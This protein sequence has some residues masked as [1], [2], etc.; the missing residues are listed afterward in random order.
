M[1]LLRCF[2]IE[3]VVGMKKGI[4]ALLFCL[5]IAAAGVNEIYAQDLHHVTYGVKMSSYYTIENSSSGKYLYKFRFTMESDDPSSYGC[6]LMKSYLYYGS[7]D[8]GGEFVVD[9]FLGTT[10]EDGELTTFEMVGTDSYT[11]KTVWT[12]EYESEE[13]LYDDSEVME[14]VMRVY[15]QG[16]YGATVQNLYISF[17]LDG[18][19][20]DLSATPTPTS[21]PEPTPTNT[22]KPTPTNTPVPTP[23]NTPV[24][25]PTNTPIP[26]NTPTPTPTPGPTLE[27]N[28]F[29]DD[30]IAV[31]QYYTGGCSPVKSIIEFYEVVETAD[32][33]TRTNS[34]TFLSGTGTMRNTM[35]PGKVY[36]Y[37]LTYIYQRDGIQYEDFLWS[38]DL[39]IVDQELEDYRNNGKITNFRTAMI[40]VWEQF[41]TLELP[42]EG[43]HI[44]FKEL[45]IWGMVASILLWVIYKFIE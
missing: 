5:L 35:I 26:T 32:I 9:R 16:N 15:F 34:E 4:F 22:P 40:C 21:T 31:A 18:E 17:T 33:L 7:Y 3:K 20:P 41:M 19:V 29:V 23:T 25:T 12:Y 42:V 8:L 43:F 45:F 24:P 39:S 14:I 13:L 30:T 6:A 2:D 37:K 28:A 11:Y 10:D 36:R 38:Q 1:V 44:S 27:L